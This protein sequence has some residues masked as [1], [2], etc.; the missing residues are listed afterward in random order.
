MT[1]NW[2][3]AFTKVREFNLH[4]AGA[5]DVPVQIATLAGL[6]RYL[7]W[8]QVK[9]C[10]LK[11]YFESENYPLVESRELLPSF[12]SDPFEY[13]H[14][15]GFSMVALGRPLSYF[16][17]IFQFDILHDLL[18][19]SDIGLDHACPLERAVQTQNRQAFLHRLPKYLQDDFKKDFVRQDLTALENY[20]KV[21]RYL[22]EMDR[23]HVLAKDKGGNF[24]LAGVYASLPSDLDTEIKRYG[25]KIGKFSVGDNVRY[26]LN[27]LFVYQFM[28][29]LYG[30]PI[31]S[32]RRTSSALFSRRLQRMGEDFMVRVLGQS[33]RTITTLYS[34]PLSKRY[35]RVEKIALV[36]VD[37]D[38]KDAL[39]MLGQGRYFVDKKKR[40]VI[41]RVVYRQHKYNA[42]N[43]RQ[44]RA[45]S[46]LRQ[47]VIHPL[48]GRIN[49]RVNIIKDASNMF[50]R[51]ND[52][53][54][55]EFTGRIVY[56]RNEVVENTDTDEKRLKFLFAWLSKHQRRIIGY[57][58]DFYSNVV[59]V[60]DNYLLN[61]EHY[62]VFNTLNDLYQEVWSKYS[63]I[64]QARKTQL[65]ENLSR[66]MHRGQRIGYLEMLETMN[67]ILHQ[68]KFEIVNYFE[69]LVDRVIAI[70]ENILH[71]P[72]LVR[73]YV[74]QKEDPL[75]GYGLEVRRNYGRLVAQLD[76]FNSIRKSRTEQ[77]DKP[78]AHAV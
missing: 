16:S 66:R 9:N 75:S 46:V 11:P 7:D 30:F 59:K 70:V 29:E 63:Y 5:D 65:L 32:E 39:R 37:P 28:M 60:L 36:Q 10:L 15:P 34:H 25:L 62:E 24:H 43:V 20:P 64:Q 42:D 26:E 40:V 71:D 31:V 19:E 8:T 12:E 67:E 48:S 58:D 47:E 76:E 6:K 4:S 33:D 21:L 45:L 77:G 74:S 17:E 35:P 2:D 72:Y 18:G 44:D 61:P 55:G 3:Q 1:F 13:A 73:K 22:L 57:T 50:L 27:R 51:L 49:D 53:V 38:M 69:E 56:K 41:L 14:L 68:L 78:R 52:I 23:A 54:R